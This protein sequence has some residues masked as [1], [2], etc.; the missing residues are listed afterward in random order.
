MGIKVSQMI[1][2]KFLKKEDFPSDQVCTIKGVKLEEVSDGE[3]RWVLHFHERDKGMVLNSTTIKVLEKAF[4][5]DSD[6]WIGKRVKV[7]VDPNVSFQGQVVGGLRLMPPRVAQPAPSAPPPP[8]PTKG[9]D[10]FG[11]EIPF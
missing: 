4:G 5:D 9:G 11:D 1:Q 3:E 8:A 7:Y 2:S 10:E 6:H